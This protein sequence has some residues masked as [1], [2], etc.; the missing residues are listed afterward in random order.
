MAKALERSKKS[1]VLL[2]LLSFH[3]TVIVPVKIEVKLDTIVAN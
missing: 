2:V 3:I 1:I